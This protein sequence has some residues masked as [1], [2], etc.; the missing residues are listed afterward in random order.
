M[1]GSLIKVDEEIVTSA[2]SSVT[3][4]GISSTYDVYLLTLNNV[5]PVTVDADVHLRVTES[6]T[7]SSDS[8]YDLAY[9]LLRTDTTFSNINLTNQAQ[10]AIS[11]SIE[12]E[13]GKTFNGHCYIFNANNSSEYTFITIENGYLADD[14]TFLGTQGGGFYSQTTTVDG[15]NISFDTGNIDAG[16]FVLFGLAK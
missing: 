6:G 4:S 13:A 5:S 2:V 16:S 9:K 11:G 10:W 14:G 15:V 7:A 12:N 1:A 8:D 3:L